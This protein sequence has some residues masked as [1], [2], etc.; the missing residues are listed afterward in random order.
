MPIRVP[1]IFFFRH[2]LF[3]AR[4]CVWLDAL[5]PGPVLN[6]EIK[7]AEILRPA[8]LAL[9]Q[10]PSRGKIGEV[11]MI[12]EDRERLTAAKF[13][14]PL[15]ETFDDGEKLLVMNLIVAF[16]DG[17]LLRIKGTRA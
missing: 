12:S 1:F 16:G 15:T 7:L 4:E 14:A 2:V 9:R 10:M 6:G 17:I 5:P 3:S 11:A 8:D 13:R